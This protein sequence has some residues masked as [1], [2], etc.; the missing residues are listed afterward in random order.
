M[1]GGGCS[2]SLSTDISG[3]ACAGEYGVVVCGALR[4][5][6][7]GCSN[8]SQWSSGAFDASCADGT[9]YDV[10]PVRDR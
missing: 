5:G 10:I 3:N 6:I 8:A 7:C 2:W 4:D 9:T 1:R